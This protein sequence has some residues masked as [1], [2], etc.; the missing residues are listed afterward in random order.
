M[1]SSTITAAMLTSIAGKFPLHTE[2]EIVLSYTQ[3]DLANRLIGPLIR[4]KVFSF[5]DALV[6]WCHFNK[7]NSIDVQCTDIEFMD[8]CLGVD[9]AEGLST[10]NP[11]F[12]ATSLLLYCNA[13]FPAALLEEQ[14]LRYVSK[15]N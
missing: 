6:L 14:E 12:F 5:E 10:V 13:K 1:S 8:R 4:R 15:K 3:D 11:A 7:V 2:M 9:P